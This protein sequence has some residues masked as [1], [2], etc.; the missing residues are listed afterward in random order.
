MNKVM[1]GSLGNAGVFW[2]FAK[3]VLFKKKSPLILIFHVTYRCN[4]RCGYCGFHE[5]KSAELDTKGALSLI[6][7]FYRLGTRFIVLSGGEP[8]LR[9]DIGEIIDSCKRKRMFIS[10]N[11]N[12]TLVQEKIDAIRNIDILKLSLDG[13]REINDRVKGLGA[14]DKVLKAIEI[15]KR[16][17]LNMGITTVIS[18]H[19]ISSFTHVLDI[20]KEYNIGVSF[21]PADQTHCGNIEKDISSEL[22]MEADFKQA[23]SFLIGEKAKGNYRINNSLAGLKHLSFWPGPKKIFCLASRLCVFLNPEGKVFVCDMFPNSQSYLVSIGSSLKETLESVSLP[24]PCQYCWS[25]STIDFNLF[26]GAK[27]NRL[28]GLGG[29]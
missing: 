10:M 8:L 23:V 20:A 9:E 17:G 14:Y 26:A 2:N 5:R 6:E 1:I 25:G 13:P 11:S 27:L 15:C 18:K 24:H 22:P 4:L 29:I 12:G 3:A 7:R 21:Q 16:K 28:W 19:N